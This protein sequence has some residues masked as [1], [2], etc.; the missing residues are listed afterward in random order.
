MTHVARIR[1]CSCCGEPFEAYPHEDRDKCGHCGNQTRME[2]SARTAAM[3]R[4]L[5]EDRRR[6]WGEADDD[7]D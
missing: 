1:V 4:Q 7:R 3:R 6:K 2:L 5:L